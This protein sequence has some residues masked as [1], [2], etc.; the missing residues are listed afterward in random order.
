MDVCVCVLGRDIFC[1]VYVLEVSSSPWLHWTYS[2]P[3]SVRM[4][5]RVWGLGKCC[6]SDCCVLTKLFCLAERAL[7]LESD[8]G[9]FKFQLL[10]ALIKIV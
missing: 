10:T 7:A 3:W 8:K 4:G 6:V 9:G 2:L 1:D 5:T